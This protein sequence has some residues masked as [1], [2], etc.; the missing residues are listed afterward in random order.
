MRKTWIWGAAASVLSVTLA[1][2]AYAQSDAQGAEETSGFGDII[3]TARREAES[4]QTVPVAVSVIGGEQIAKLGT[5]R[6]EDIA[7][8]APGLAIGVGGDTDRGNIIF[9]I[10][11]QNFTYGA[12]FPSVI[13]YFN[14]VPTKYLAVGQFYDT[15]ALQVLRGPQGVQF[16]RVT[17]GGNVMF[18]PKK[19]TDELS[20]DISLKAGDYNLIGTTGFANVPLGD[21]LSVRFSWDI[22]KRDGFTRNLYNGTKVDDLN[23]KG[24]RIGVLWKPSDRFENYLVAQYQY[25][26]DNGTSTH[27]VDINRQGIANS[28]SGLFPLVNLASELG[29]R[30]PVYGINP[31]TGQVGAYGANGNTLPLNVDNFVNAVQAHVDRQNQLGKRKIY[32]TMPMFNRRKYFYAVNTMSFDLN[33]NLQIKNILG[34]TRFIE[35]SG[36]NFTGDNSGVVTPCHSACPFQPDNTVPFQNEEQLSAE[37]RLSG[38]V[39]DNRL[40][41]S[42]GGYMDKQ[43]PGGLREN[44]TIFGGILE[45]LVLQRA[46]TKSKAVYG[47]AEFDITDQW[48]VNGG[49]RYTHDTIRSLNANYNALLPVP[50]LEGMIA[51]NLALFGTPAEFIPYVANLTANSASLVHHGK[52]ED[53]NFGSFTGTCT[54]TKGKFNSTTWT[55]GTSFQITPRQLVYAKYS[56]GYRPGGVNATFPAG[57][58]NLRDFAPENNFSL[59]AGLKSDFQFGSV[60]VRTNLAVYKDRYKGIQSSIQIRDTNGNPGSIVTNVAGAKIWGVEFEG[61]IR[62]FEGFTIG[63]NYSYT[64]AR[65]NKGGL[66]LAEIDIGPTDPAVSLI[67]GAS[68]TYLA[69][70]GNAVVNLGFCTFNRFP[71]TPAHQAGVNVQWDFIRDQEGVGTMGI[72]GNWYYQSSIA[73]S[74]GKNFLTPHPTQP[75]YSLFN[76]NAN[77]N[78]MLGSNLDLMLFVTNVTNKVYTVTFNNGLELSGIGNL[79]RVYAP[80]RMFGGTLTAHF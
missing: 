5:F 41:W 69:C 13:T 39:F 42:L 71:L 15:E 27:L 54:E 78:N 7:Q 66:D 49:A 18:T 61:S 72:G 77:W 21:T 53:F 45:Y 10:R 50:G 1:S 65:Y 11:G 17:N 34:Y 75:S 58:E 9:S 32:L 59:E 36:Q 22:A 35:R 24:G 3:V 29:M 56:K 60:P 57:F 33:D 4:L 68:A 8:T 64:H 2:G 31:Q 30:A 40:S 80:P 12:L 23:Y 74:T 55:F 47:Y 16:G 63:G 6:P 37:L 70:N 26:D 52:C 67:D 79:T 73:S 48:K 25:T 51:A 14:D 43:Q 20:A 44:D 38:K 28:V 19:P 46:K 76:L 62:P